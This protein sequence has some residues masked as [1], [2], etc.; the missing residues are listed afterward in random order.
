VFNLFSLYQMKMIGVIF[1]QLETSLRET[2]RL[3]SGP[4]QQIVPIR[5]SIATLQD[6]ARG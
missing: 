5:K 2:L 1:R 4:E 6:F 3:I